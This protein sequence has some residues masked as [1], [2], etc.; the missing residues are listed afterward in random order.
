MLL[1]TWNVNSARARL[2]RMLEWLHDVRPDVVCLQETKCSDE[3]FPLAQLSDAGYT[4]AHHGDGRWNGVAILSR[5]GVSDVR[6][7]LPDD[8]RGADAES[9]CLAATCGG[10]R[11]YSVYV[12]NGRSVGDPHYDYKLRWLAAL[13]DDLA[14]QPTDLPLVVAGDFNVAPAD[15]DVWDPAAF[16][17]STHVTKPE[18][19]A[20]RALGDLGLRDVVRE[21]NPEPGLYSYYDY[22]A[23]MFRRDMG[24]RIDL[25]LASGSVA[26]AV[27][28]AYVDREA[29]RGTGA[30]DH[31]P[32]LVEFLGP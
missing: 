24:M 2:P 15:A 4:V 12:P 6:P 20:V 21:Q 10:V 3:N 25:V 11:C 28:R 27:T 32:V 18:R 16:L 19:A 17:G 22:R 9:R 1:A 31:A 26:D 13:R 14:A 5:I 8:P 30:S 23:G 7:G 29:R